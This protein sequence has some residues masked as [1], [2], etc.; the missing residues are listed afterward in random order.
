MEPRAIMLERKTEVRLVQ[1]CRQGEQDAFRRL[2]DTYKDRV[3]S[4]AV[5]FLQGDTATAEDVCQEVF[6]RLHDSIRQFRHD[7]DFSTWLYRIVANACKDEMRKRRRLVPL[8]SLAEQR[9]T[10]PIPGDCPQAELCEAVQ[11][12]LAELNPDI[13]LTL[14]LKYFEELSYEEMAAALDCPMGTIASRLNRGLKAMA[15]KLAY[16]RRPPPSGE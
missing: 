1:A 14:L 3:Y 9:D 5:Y 2:F 4:I 12:A 13:R 10:A 15:R 8:D 11:S 7:S 16:L 6:L